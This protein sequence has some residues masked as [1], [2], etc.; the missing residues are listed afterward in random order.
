MNTPGFAA[1]ASLY[2]TNGHYQGDNTVVVNKQ[3]VLPQANCY[4]HCESPGCYVCCCHLIDYHGI[5]VPEC[6]CTG[7]A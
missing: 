3:T 2:R 4:V 5:S 1:E 6:E 7:M